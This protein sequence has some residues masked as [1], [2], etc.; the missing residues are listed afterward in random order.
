MRKILIFSTSYHPT[1]AGAEIAIKEIT[2]RLEKGDFAFDM[3]TL[4]F[5][6]T[7]LSFEKI[8][9]VNV[10][11]II[12]PK[13]LFPFLAYFKALALHRKNRY[14]IIW[15]MMAGRNGFAALFLKLTYPKLKF[16]L[17][18]QEGD[19]LSYPKERAGVFWF[20]IGGLFKKI[21]TKADFVQV[22]SKYLRQWA[23]DMGYEGGLEVIPNGADIKNFQ[24]SI[25]NSQLKKLKKELGITEKEKVIITTSRLVEK[26]AVEDI[27]KALTFLPSNYKLLIAG[28]GSL[29]YQLRQMTNDLQLVKRVLFLG[30]IKHNELPQYLHIS[31]VFVRPSL[32][33][34]LGSSF[35]EAMASGVPI[36][37]TQVGGITDF[38]KDGYTGLYCGVHDSRGI[39]EKIEL[40]VKNNKLREKII[41]NAKQMVSEKYDWDLIARDMKGKVFDKMKENS[42]K[43]ILVATGLFPPDIG[44]P[45]TYSKLLFDELPKRGFDITIISFGEVRYLPKIIRH[46]V[47][48]FKI[49]NRAK[50]TDVIFAQDPVSVGFSAVLASKILQKKFLLKVVGDYAWEQYQQSKVSLKFSNVEEF[51]NKK[52]DMLTEMRRKIERWV[53]K[54]AET[55]IVPSNYLK[56][57]I[58]M[59]GIDKNN[60]NIIHNGFKCGVECGNRQT[61][62]TLLQFKGELIISIGRLVPWKGFDT[63]IEIFPN[64]KS[65]FKDAKLIIAG[66]GSD[67]EKLQKL[68][69]EKGLSNDIA[70]TGALKK[71]VLLRYIKA[72]DIFVLNTGYE[73]FSHQLLEVMDVGVPIVTTDVGGNPEIIENEKNGLLI[74]YNDKKGIE[75]AVNKLLKDRKYADKLV[76]E[77]KKK[78]QEFSEE[79]MIRETAEVLKNI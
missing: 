31:D 71:D 18:L 60:I 7:L 55:I 4:R 62:R 76:K 24:F 6:K 2:D 21:F 8:G 28:T 20:V 73:G 56:K 30:D 34:G 59:W 68:I 49:I 38:L 47:Y 27:I 39:S 14:D 29:F 46:I 26:N 54:N 44:G 32:T 74:D 77:A 79:R 70:L 23:Y 13:L 48:F 40:L 52:Y 15:S 1:M 42:N 57:I 75:K 5:D 66:S 22:I 10:H 17:T 43:N 16:L 64:I 69:D 36:I 41:K 11:R 61:L 51:Q 19:R 25:T 35:I 9:N 3:V 50:K 65:K 58:S 33:E 53:A 63:L 78:V 45:A 37:A 72:S 67:M 12:S